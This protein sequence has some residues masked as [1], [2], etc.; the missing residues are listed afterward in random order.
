MHPL[1]R[2]RF[3]AASAASLALPTAATAIDPIRRT[4]QAPLRL[5]V[6]AYSY[7]QYL[8]LKKP[9]QPAMTLDDFIDK[10]AACACDGVELTQYYFPETAPAYLARL[11]AR[12]TRLG[13]DVSGTAVR[14][15]FCTADPAKL[16]ADLKSVKEWTEHTARLG[17]K[18]MRV[19][20]GNTP[21]GDTEERARARCIAALQE[22]CEHAARYGVYLALENHGGITSTPEQLLAIVAA[23]KSDFFGVNLDGGNFHTADPYA[24]FGKVAP[25]AVTVQIKTEVQPGGGPKQPADLKR[26]VALLRQANYRGYVVLEHE[27]AEDPLA[28]VPRHLAELRR[29]LG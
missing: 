14:N 22:A 4:G 15:D 26:Q 24:D 21:R 6:A 2:R 7:R 10:A 27:A 19:F 5:S 16:A 11:K 3:L 18:T 25:Y 29:I 9:K 1:S 23:V 8:D 17:G 12:C 28:A 13:L 20:A